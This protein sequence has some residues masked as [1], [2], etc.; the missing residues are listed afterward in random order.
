VT[1]VLIDGVYMDKEEEFEQQPFS[2]AEFAENP[3]QR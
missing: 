3:E 1:H 2:G